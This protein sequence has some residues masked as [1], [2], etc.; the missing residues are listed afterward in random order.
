MEKKPPLA[1]LTISV[2]D[3]D[4]NGQ[5]DVE[6]KLEAFGIELPPVRVPLSLKAGLDFIF[7]VFG[8]AKKLGK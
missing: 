5:A 3:S 7:G 8:G 6:G 2:G 4:N 1:V